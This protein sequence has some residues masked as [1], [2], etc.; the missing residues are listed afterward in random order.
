MR[1]DQGHSIS[2]IGI[3]G[4]TFDPIHEAHLVLAR[5]SLQEFALDR[6]LL[7]PAGNPPH[8]PDLGRT[9][10]EHRYRMVQLACGASGEIEPSRLEEG[11]AKSYTFDTLTRIRESIAPA[12]LL[13]LILGADAFAEIET[14]HRWREVIGMATFVVASRPGYRYTIPDGATV[15]R[16]ETLQRPDSSSSIRAQL[17]KGMRPSGVSDEVWRYIVENRLYSQ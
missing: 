10:F 8:K 17:R 11:S 9:P 15:L 2:R 7:I 3:L 14:W 6:V 16:M 12:D 13:F 4:G 5:E 1:A